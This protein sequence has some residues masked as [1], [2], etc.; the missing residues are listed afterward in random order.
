M[1][2]RTGANYDTFTSSSKWRAATAKD[3]GE[4]IRAFMDAL[5]PQ[6]ISPEA[7]DTWMDKNPDYSVNSTY[8]AGRESLR[9]EIE[10]A[11]KDG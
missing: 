7:T 2:R 11:L 4:I 1:A 6:P 10:E 9:R 3:L 8:N 5:P